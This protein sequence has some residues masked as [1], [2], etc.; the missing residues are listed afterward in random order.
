[1][2][3]AVG[4]RYILQF[5]KIQ[6]SSTLELDVE[7]NMERKAWYW[8]MVF[9]KRYVMYASNGMLIPVIQCGVDG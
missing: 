9:L 4:H 3:V 7:K 1:M 5:Y 2:C 6:R 8:T